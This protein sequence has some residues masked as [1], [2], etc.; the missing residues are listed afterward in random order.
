MKSLHLKII[1]GLLALFFTTGSALALDLEITGEIRTGLYVENREQG[2]ETYSYT[3]MHN[4]DG[5]S[6]KGEGL[7]RIGLNLTQENFGLRFRFFQDDFKRGTSENDRNVTRIKTDYAYAYGEL[8]NSQFKI[9]AGL[10]GESPWATGGPELFYE[11]EYTNGMVEPI[12]GIRFEWKPNFAP[13]LNGL[14]L[15]FVLNRQDDTVPSDAIQKFGDLFLESI[16]G[17]AWEH[18]YFALRFAYRF[19]RGIDSPAAV[20][21]GE[22][23]VYRVE[24]RI[25]GK[26]LPGMQIWAN[27]YGYG[28]NAK[29]GGSGRS[30][31]SWIQNW[32]YISYDPENF[33]AGLNIGYYDAYVTNGQQLEFRP[34]F[35]WKFF[36]NT[37][38]VGL[39]AGLEM[40][41]NN[42][43]QSKDDFY[44][45]WF[46]E[47][48]VKVNITSNLYAA[49]VYRF[50]VYPPDRV[51]D[52]QDK[53]HWI[54]IRLVY[55]F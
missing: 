29:E 39:M 45:F 46:L 36:N 11:L 41:F 18:E 52:L 31:T 47:P 32:L 49:A 48:Q 13:F 40:G 30:E 44:N 16:V 23:F 3:K 9:S 7:L 35:Y 25:L 17:I 26:F 28:I 34:S 2:G 43:K 53:T 19:D 50:K 5:D 42:S 8:L 22:R 20:V 54:N 55:A 27:G 14:N 1:T 38:V 21:N 4:N 10:L 24:E 12:T 33:T 37:L 51:K 6:G 15:G